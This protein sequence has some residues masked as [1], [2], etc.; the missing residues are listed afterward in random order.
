SDL[1]REL[2][3][4]IETEADEQQATG[5]PPEE[6]RYAARRALGNTTQ[7]KEDVRMAWGFQWLEKLLQDLRYGLRTMR[8]SPG[9]TMVAVLSLALGIGANTAIFSLMNAVM[10]RD[11]PVKKPGQ[12]VLLGTGRSAGSTGDFARTDLYSY[13]FYREMQ[14]KNQVFSAVSAVLSLTFNG[15]HGAVGGSRSLEPMD[16]QL[17]SGTYFSMLGVMPILGRAFTRADDEPAGGHP[18]AVISY[19]WW[20][21]RFALDP[22]VLGK[23][24]TLGSTVYTIIGVTP[25]EFFGAAVGQSP[26]LWIPLSMEK[27]VSPGWN[28]LADKSFQSLYILGRL[29]PAVTV[30]QA[31]AN[32]NLLA[33]QI[34]HE[35]AG[36]V[37]TKEQQIA[38]KRANIQLTPAARGLSRLR[39][40]FSLPLQILMA[41]VGLVLLIAC[42]NIAN[43]L[44]ARATTRQREIAVRMAIG[45][46]R[47]RLIRQM[48]TE[49]FLMAFCGGALGVA[50]AWWAN[51]ALL[52]MVSAGPEPLPLNVAPDAGVLTFTF[53]VSLITALLFGVV[54]A[55]R[56]TRIDLTPS[57]KEGRG[58]AAVT[59]ASRLS[60]ALIV[61][62]VALSLLLLTGAGLFLRTLVNLGNVNTGFNKENV[63]LFGIDPVD[64]GYKL[65][66]RLTSLYEQI[67]QRVSAQPG[68][69][70]ASIS[71]FTFNQGASDGPVE[72]EGRNL[73]AGVDNDVI[74]NVVGQGYFATMGIPVLLGRVFTADDTARSPK[75]A[76]INET[77]AR[78]FFPGGSPLGRRFGLDPKHSSDI[79]VVGVVKD[80][81]YISLREKRW[82]A[83][84]YPYSQHID[85]YYYDLEIRY[86]GNPKVIIAEVRGTVGEVD[87]NL[88]LTYNDTLAQQVDRSITSQSLIARLSAFFGLLAVFLACIG[89]YGVMSYAITRR[90]N[91][92]GI[93]MALG[94]GR[95][96]VLWMVMRESLT[97]AVVGIAVGAPAAL[98]ADR[99]VSR[100]LFGISPSD[101][102]SMAG[103]AALL[104]VFAA[105]AGYLPA[106]RAAW[107]DPMV[108]LRYE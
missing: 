5:V 106:R 61:S 36:L 85:S 47:A 2:K 53:V 38:L 108:A 67:E 9:L 29:K 76:V 105:L 70:A 56:A 14:Q 92:I 74:H 17:V 46:G 51:E 102:L 52:A 91:E 84:Y 31:H 45:A 6:A 78:E 26:N 3:T 44:L 55:L 63:L 10:L 71:F 98:A 30:T 24:A 93:R 41:V 59:G 79:E 97:L 11:L 88:P 65:D 60:K 80:A 27:Q 101:P 89:L 13:P 37:L 16:V 72:V 35:F 68:V 28:G 96:S 62:Q 32:V 21:R 77:M 90:T 15:M 73:P 83:A 43:L 49:S 81:K 69:R 104:V 22:S 4:H 107:V 87:H 12:L 82:P 75:V 94:S 7:I 50:L 1:D 95:S 99:L 103:A 54:P 34:W 66:A 64:V 20:K 39:F 19:S 25:P 48:L 40:Q 18:I 86:S 33:K 100:M 57:L 42:A 23:T 8:R 58:M